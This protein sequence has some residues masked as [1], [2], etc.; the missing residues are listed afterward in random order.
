MILVNDPLQG[1]AVGET[2]LVG[3]GRD[4]G[5][6]EE[7]V[8]EERG[9]VAAEAHLFD[10]VGKLGSGCLDALQR[11]LGLPL[12][13]D[14]Q[15]GQSLPCCGEGAEVGGVGDALLKLPD[16]GFPFVVI[17]PAIGEEFVGRAARFFGSRMSS[18]SPWRTP[19]W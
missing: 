7:V 9:L 15:F 6:G 14:V 16:G 12:V 1:G 19:R 4:A 18:F 5:E 2:V 10:A 8:I 11:V 3:F 17:G 13:V